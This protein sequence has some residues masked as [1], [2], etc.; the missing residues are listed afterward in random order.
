[1]DR[2]LTTQSDVLTI[3]HLE[4][5]VERNPA[6]GAWIPRAKILLTPN[7]MSQDDAPESR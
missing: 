4:N 7:D 5:S 6:E 1:M 2:Y 3:A